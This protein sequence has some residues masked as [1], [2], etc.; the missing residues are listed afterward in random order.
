MK[1][2]QTLEGALSGKVALEEHEI[3]SGQSALG[4][5]YLKPPEQ[6]PPSWLRLFKGLLDISLVNSSSS[7]VMILPV[8]KRL[9]ALTFGYGRSLLSPG[10]VEEQFGLKV[11]LNGVGAQQIRSVDRLSLDTAQHSR[12]QAIRL[13]PIGE[14]GLDIDQDLL[15]AVTGVPKDETLG[16]SLTG[17]DAL[18]V[19]V[20]LELQDLPELLKRLLEEYAKKDYQEEFPWVDQIQEVSDPSIKDR[21]D[22]QLV[23]CLRN[24]ELDA[25]WLAVPEIIDWV[26]IKAFKY[27]TAKSAPDFPDLHARQ[28]LASLK[29]PKSV[30]VSDLKNRRV[31]AISPENDLATDTW[32]VYRCLYSE[33]AQGTDTYVLSN[34]TWY[35]IDRNFVK[36]VTKAVD[37]VPTPVNVLPPFNDK[38]EAAYNIRVSKAL[39]YALMD[40]KTVTFPGGADKVEVCDLYTS[41]KEFIHVK[42]F[43]G[44]APLSHLFSQGVV[45]AEL[46]LHEL[47]CIATAWLRKRADQHS[48]KPAEV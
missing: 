38:D 17:R 2:A 1:E 30:T 48:S 7:A 43:A 33:Q 23:N 28:F 10:A 42:Q 11:T 35:R 44:S 5:L 24:E 6:H 31:H 45:S 18:Q 13:T 34:A 12:V 39:G 4:T 21:L 19:T 36:E 22:E 8:A 27:S 41:K 15:R 40:R 9:F 20:K 25:L 26:R 29:E 16:R 37:A 46:F 47:H 32:P 3:R 14:F